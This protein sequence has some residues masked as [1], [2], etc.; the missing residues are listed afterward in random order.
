M[1]QPMFD[2]QRKT[3]A[4]SSLVVNH[5]S[6]VSIPIA[7]QHDFPPYSRLVGSAELPAGTVPESPTPLQIAMDRDTSQISGM[8]ESAPLVLRTKVAAEPLPTPMPGTNLGFSADDLIGAPPPA[9]GQQLSTSDPTSYFNIPISE[10]SEH[11]RLNAVEREAVDQARARKG[12]SGSATFLQRQLPAN[13]A[14][15]DHV[16]ANHSLGDG[17]VE[18]TLDT[19]CNPQDHELTSNDIEHIVYEHYPGPRAG[20][21]QPT[22]PP[23]SNPQAQAQL[24]EMQVQALPSASDVLDPPSPET[25]GTHGSLYDGTGY[26]DERSSRPSTSSTAPKPTAKQACSTV[27]ATTLFAEDSVAMARDHETLEEVIRAYAAFE[28]DGV[29]GLSED[30]LEDVVADVELANRLADHSLGA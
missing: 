6:P 18:S 28:E 27:A 4:S 15:S 26:G 3:S 8:T 13:V 22:L 24:V 7:A 11:T 14:D 29:S 20:C 16:T 12:H 19:R 23:N 9:H 1:G 30:V 17:D 21:D 25:W 2:L 10:R 5:S